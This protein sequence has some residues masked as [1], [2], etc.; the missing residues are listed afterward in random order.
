M[1]DAPLISVVIPTFRRPDA[2][3]RAL[4]SVLAHASRGGSVEV[5]VVDNDARRSAAPTVSALQVA[6]TLPIR[7]VHEPA[8]G[9]ANARNAGV[10]AARGR[11]IAFLDDD[12]TA[13]AE[14][15]P[16]A[17]AVQRRFDADVVFGPVC[18]AL[19]EGVPHS[20]YLQRFFSRLGPAQ[21][22]A[23]DSYYGCGGAFIRRQS[24]PAYLPFSPERNRIGGEDDLLFGQM[25]G[26]GARF[27]WAARAAVIEHPAVERLTLAYTLRRAFAY[28]QGPASAAWAGGPRHWGLAPLW[29]GW[30]ALQAVGFGAVAAVKWAL[31]ADDRAEAL[32]R[33][34]QGLGKL[35][36]FPPFKIA[37]YGQA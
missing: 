34:A 29:M 31:S 15:L 1:S 12:E 22:R 20:A 24:L 36:W 10:A 23:L 32:D 8:A 17:L 16:E 37:F 13:T 5:V 2:L 26:R 21:D 14:W 30:G 19:P 35:L 27:A 28:G 3:A 4:E 18:A 9:V 7:Y 6:A 11:F 25:Q 33:A